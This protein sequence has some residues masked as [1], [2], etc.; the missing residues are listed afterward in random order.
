MINRFNASASP[1]CIKR[2]NLQRNFIEMN[3]VNIYHDVCSRVELL[4]QVYWSD[5][6]KDCVMDRYLS[7]HSSSAE[8]DRRNK[9]SSV[10]LEPPRKRTFRLFGR[11]LHD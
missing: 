8:C 9:P 4:E 5:L 11:R 3:D 10:F 6:P 7:I 1:N 2:I